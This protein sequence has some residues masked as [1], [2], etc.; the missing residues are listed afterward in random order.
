MNAQGMDPF[1][2]SGSDAEMHQRERNLE[3][4]DQDLVPASDDEVSSISKLKEVF[5][6]LFKRSK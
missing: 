5:R 2:T 4:H 3:R 1:H 6:R